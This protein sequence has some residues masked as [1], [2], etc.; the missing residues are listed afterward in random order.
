MFT[1]LIAWSLHNRPLILA[2]TIILC[3]LGGYTLKRMPVD[4]FPEFAP[5]QVVVQ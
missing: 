3:L 5:P 2:L 1:R 4:V